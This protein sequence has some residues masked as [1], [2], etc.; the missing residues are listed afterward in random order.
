MRGILIM[1]A[2]LDG[3][4]EGQFEDA[5]ELLERRKARGVTCTRER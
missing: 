4:V 1:V 2:F 5:N 3:H